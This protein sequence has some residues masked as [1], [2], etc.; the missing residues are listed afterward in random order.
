MAFDTEPDTPAR[1]GDLFVE[2]RLAKFA[3]I[4]VGTWLNAADEL[5]T[6]TIMP[7]VARDIGGYAWFGWAVATFLLGSILG[8]ATAGRLSASLGL[9][10]AIAVGGSI[11]ALGCVASALS[12]S[13]AWFLIG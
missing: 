8:G 12:P 2:G 4:C 5:M 10:R 1:W 7:S 13:V 3:L 11:Y 6:A 9:R